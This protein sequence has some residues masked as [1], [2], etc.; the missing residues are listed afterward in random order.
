MSMQNKGAD[1][2]GPDD[3][4]GARTDTGSA[5]SVSTGDPGAIGGSVAGKDGQQPVQQDSQQGAM[6]PSQT[7]DDQ[8]DQGT[9]QREP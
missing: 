2:K 8:Y 6:P 3:H 4:Q 7:D 1:V 9:V 5:D